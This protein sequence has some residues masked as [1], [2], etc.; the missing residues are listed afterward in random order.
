MYRFLQEPVEKPRISPQSASISS[1]LRSL[2]RT[3]Y[4]GKSLGQAVDTWAAMLDSRTTVILGLAGAM[5]PAGM[6]ELFVYLIENRLIDCIASTGANLFHDCHESLGRHHYRGSHLTDDVE[7]QKC[8]VDRIYDVFAS[9]SEFRQTDAFIADFS[10]GLPDGRAYT[11]REFLFELGVAVGERGGPPGI[12]TAAAKND[13]PLYCPAIGDSSIG[14]A[15][16]QARAESGKIVIFDVIKDAMELARIVDNSPETG[17]IY[18]GGGTPKNFIQQ[19]SIF[20]P[21]QQ[22]AH[23]FAIQITTDSPQWGGL[24]GCTFEEAQSWGKIMPFAEKVSVHCDATIAFPIL[25]SALA[26]RVEDII[27]RRHH[28][29]FR[30][31]EDDVIVE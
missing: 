30:F 27:S 31:D 7:L 28:P 4:Q 13:V 18:I 20:L 9:E 17:V 5:I 11:T 12:L 2:S 10:R 21:G 8:G 26:E 25:V 29:V 1:L 22:S 6:R 24:S 3:A 23:K 14:I 16:G 19:A 15:L